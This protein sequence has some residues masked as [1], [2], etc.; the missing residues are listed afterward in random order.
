MAETNTKKKSSRS[1][2]LEFMRFFAAIFMAL[3]HFTQFCYPDSGYSLT[4]TVYF[5]E[6]FFMISGYFMMKSICTASDKAKLPA[7]HDAF[8]YTLKK[9]SAIWGCYISAALL[10][11]A[12]RQFLKADFSLAQC[13][14]ELFHGKWEF[15]MLQMAG[16]NYNPQ[17]GIDYLVIPGWFLSSMFIALVPCYYLAR[18]FERDYSGVVA[19]I[20]A[21]VIYC[22]IIQTYGSIDVGN[23][24]LGGLMLGVIRA[25]A[26]ISLG[27]F[28]YHI[29]ERLTD[30][31]G[32]TVGRNRYWNIFNV[33]SFLTVFVSVFLNFDIISPPDLMFY[34]IPVAIII[35]S[36]DLDR[37]VVSRW[38]NSHFVKSSLYLGG[39]SMYVFIFHT[40]PL[41][42]WQE[43]VHLDNVYISGILYLAATV[44]L[45]ALFQKLQQSLSKKR[46]PR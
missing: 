8:F 41:L 39:L 21:M 43:F 10:T 17:F 45:S 34:L 28:V 19:P 32:W 4:H 40:I 18:R 3:I 44:L 25:F 16:F 11:F 31:N 23:Q 2:S 29:S 20:S 7:A 26:G 42:L 38:L 14:L 27:T 5:V 37:G 22:Y 24:F 9:A 15:L 46:A 13:F 35:I 12:I 30:K 33:L 36:A 6:M 1:A